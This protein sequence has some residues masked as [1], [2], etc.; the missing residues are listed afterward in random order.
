MFRSPFANQLVALAASVL[1]SFAFFAY[2]VVPA[3]PGLV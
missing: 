3:S 1:V 2:A